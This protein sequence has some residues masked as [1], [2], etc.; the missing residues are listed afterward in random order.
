MLGSAARLSSI[1]S[2]ILISH[3]PLTLSAGQMM[4]TLSGMSDKCF[5]GF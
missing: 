3:K 5:C 2:S 1:V 4:C